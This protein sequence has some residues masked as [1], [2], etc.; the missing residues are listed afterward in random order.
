MQ[1]VNEGSMN[2]SRKCCFYFFP[3]ENSHQKEIKNRN[4]RQKKR[5]KQKKT[6]VDRKS[7]ALPMS[8]F[9]NYFT[10]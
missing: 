8:V 6:G 10:E 3:R 5:K 1:K 9:W 7:G 4:V 2:S